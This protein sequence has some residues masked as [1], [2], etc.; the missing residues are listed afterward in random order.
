MQEIRWHH[1]AGILLLSFATLILELTL[2]RVLSIANWYHFSFLVIST[3]LLGFGASGVTLSL[4]HKLREKFPLD[5]ALAYLSWCFA[6][7][8]IASFILMQHIPFRPFQ[9]F[10]DHWQLLYLP[11]YYLV[12][13]APFYC[14]G[15]ALALLFSRAGRQVNR[16]YG[17]DLVGA[18]IGCAAVCFVLPIFGGAGSVVVA[19]MFGVLAGLAFR[20]FRPVKITTVGAIIAGAL[21]VLALSDERF[22]P[23]HVIPEKTHPL[24]PVHQS[25]IYSKWNSFSKVDVYTI[26]AAPASGRPYAGYSIIVD[27]GLS[28]T[29]IPDLSAGV[30]EFLAH[31]PKYQPPGLAYIEKTHPKIL[32]IGS[33][34][35]REI[36]EALYFHAS[37]I[38]AVEIDPTI[39]DV[40]SNRMAKQWGGLFEQPEVHLATEDG[41]SFVR[42]SK[43]KYDAI[44]SLQ[45][46]SGAALTSG[47]LALSEA[48]VLTREAF[49]DYWNHLTPEG[50]LLVTRPPAQ[51]PKLFATTRELFNRLSL[52]S[53]ASHL[54][55]FRGLVE[56]F[57]HRQ[58]LTGMLLSKSPL[59]PGSVQELSRRLGIGS[60][61]QWGDTGQPEFFYSPY[62]TPDN[63]FQTLL[64]D[65]LNTSDLRRIYRSSDELLNPATDDS[66]F[67]NQRARWSNIHRHTI[68]AALSLTS[69]DDVG[70]LPVSQVTLLVLFLQV[71][72]VAAVL[73]LL[74]LA[75]FNKRRTSVPGRWSFLLYFAALGL[76]FILIEVGF[77]QR[78]E[79][80]IGRPIYTFS[81]VLAGL[82]V[83]SGI[84][85]C[86]AHRFQNVT[87]RTLYGVLLAVFGSTL[88]T[89]LVMQ[90]LLTITLGFSLPLR[91]VV[92]LILISQIGLV[93]GLPFSTGLRLVASE[94]APLVPWAWAVNGFFTVIGSVAA[95]I[96]GTLVGFSPMFLI[97]ALSYAVAL[98]A[99]HARKSLDRALREERVLVSVPPLKHHAAA[100]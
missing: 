54:V 35:G 24:L 1:Y 74:P 92:A 90:P 41:R 87:R 6:I 73:I 89:W 12:L 78:F 3:A 65:I 4:W 86:L 16:L 55:A 69:N 100:R 52:G 58:F 14:S 39:N 93:L 10:L 47:A 99:M 72:T 83:S 38:T 7:V 56:P 67:F 91:I 30:K 50:V 48:Y 68:R 31:S 26:A 27:A 81:I 36:L 59:L 28:G 76:G 2:T 37:S 62:R 77:L 97:A 44:I 46:M 88:F 19:V 60:N 32:I 5:E 98:A 21:F 20:S 57:G 17:A 43:E 84:G 8:S 75:S 11:V 51:I 9:L 23:I 66:P 71:T 53:P 34:A 85:S 45:T 33:G 49:E 22:L 25:P 42:R 64:A 61:Q 95:M 63:H 13:A 96:L 18:G 94:A 79:L 80:Y 15:L 29:A 40:V 70:N 82:L